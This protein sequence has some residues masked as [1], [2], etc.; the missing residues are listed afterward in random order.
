[1][2][3]PPRRGA[4]TV[5]SSILGAGALFL[6]TLA[7]GQGGPAAVFAWG[8]QCALGVPLIATIGALARATGETGVAGFA[9]AALGP[10][11]RQPV[12]A[13]YLVGFLAGQAVIA[14]VAGTY[15]ADATG[16]GGAAA[17]GLGALALAAAAALAIAGAVPRGRARGLISAAVAALLVALLVRAAFAGI[18]PARTA[19]AGWRDVGR[20]T[21]LLF[22]AFVGWE[23]AARA[24]VPA[25]RSVLV[26]A[27]A[28]AGAAAA[29]LAPV[30]ASLTLVPFLAGDASGAGLVTAGCCAAIA[31][32]L[33]SANLRTI[34][35][36]W[37]ELRSTTGAA[38]AARSSA[39]AAVAVAGLL[40]LEYAVGLGAMLRVPNATALFVYALAGG[41]GVLLLRGRARVVAATGLAGTVAVAPFAGW[42]LLVPTTVCAA[43]VALGGARSLGRE[44]GPHLLRPEGEER[45][46]VG[47]RH[48]R[49]GDGT[50]ALERDR[51]HDPSGPLGDEEGALEERRRA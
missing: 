20:T 14:L 3:A 51:G 22:F 37:S 47:R 5:A 19:D 26:V 36:L 46:D 12:T 33:C 4:L 2:S 13:C 23:R 27:L 18:S 40:A 16:G 25:V 45:L 43:G 1:V 11:W 17:C 28:Y 7:A 10:R 50:A 21:F 38:T 31:V 8:W 35:G 6:P 34:A 24:R 44:V 29:A 32:A 30:R 39:L 49:V 48:E 15:L 41:A 9:A 42:A